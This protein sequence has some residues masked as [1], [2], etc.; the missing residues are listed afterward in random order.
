MV[1]VIAY[2]VCLYLIAPIDTLETEIEKQLEDIKEDVQK[3][4][5]N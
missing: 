5:G 2:I 4:L 3:P 1:R